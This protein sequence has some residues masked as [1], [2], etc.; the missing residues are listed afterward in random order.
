MSTQEQLSYHL[1]IPQLTYSLVKPRVGV[2]IWGRFTGKTE[3]PGVDFTLNNILSMPRSNGFI[4]GRTYSQLTEKT[5]DALVAGWEKR[6]FIENKHFW[7]G[8]FP[9]EE[10]QIPK[11]IRQPISPKHYISWFNGSG[12]Y[13]VSQDKFSTINGVR[14]QWGFIDEAK[15]INKRKFDEQTIPTMA[16]G[17]SLWGHQSNYLS[18][19]FCSDMPQHSSEKWLLDYEKYH[20]PELINIILA[21][22]YKITQLHSL[23]ESVPETDLDNFKKICSQISHYTSLLNELRK[24][25]IYYST[26]SALDNI[27]AIGIEPLK[28]S[29]RS[30]SDLKFRVQVLNEK[31]I[32]NE[33]GF[34]ALLDPLEHSDNLV[35]FDF[36]SRS[37]P[38]SPRD[39]RW[40]ADAIPHHPLE[41][42]C[43]HNSAINSIVTCQDS[44]GSIRFLSS[45]YV[46]H[47]L[48]LDSLID[49]WCDYYQYHPHK[50]V[51]Y[52]FDSTSK[53]GNSMSDIKEWQEVVRNLTLRG[54]T[55]IQ[56]DIGQIGSHTSRYF[57]WGK[58]F[59]GDPRLPRFVYNRINC[60]DWETSCLQAGLIRV[61]DSYKK[62]KSSEKSDSGV[63]PY[64]ATHLSEAGDILMWG[65]LRKLFSNN[66]DFIGLISST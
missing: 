43:D 59:S 44:L 1:N 3:G 16:G 26:A 34:Y 27:D 58:L 38:S 6:G 45:M 35:N 36:V 47:P 7:I 65:K 15:L 14:S 25:C 64:E 9:D 40:D 61:G 57:L 39:C 41:I 32:K 56:M 18:L 62:D 60:K 52:W 30:L 46:L 55:V 54:W 12:I 42:A 13:L 49:K 17:F 11:A 8:K 22:Q 23:L 5:L 48:L 66:S 19:L 33:T 53:K 63:P 21:T 37:L 31:I 50:V 24:H 2:C 4:Q 20:D 51:Y 29:K 10:L 28:N